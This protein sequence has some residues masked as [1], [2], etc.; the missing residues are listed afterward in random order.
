MSMEALECRYLDQPY[1]ESMSRPAGET[2]PA[3]V[4]MELGRLADQEPELTAACARLSETGCVVL[5]LA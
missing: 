4:D 3:T 5:L 1:G 2:L